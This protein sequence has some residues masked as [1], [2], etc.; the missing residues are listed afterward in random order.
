ML[1][2]IFL[3]LYWTASSWMQNSFPTFTAAQLFDFLDFLLC[4]ANNIVHSSFTTYSTAD[5]FPLHTSTT[6]P[7]LPPLFSKEIERSL[8]GRR[9]LVE[10]CSNKLVAQ[11]WFYLYTVI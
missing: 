7:Q 8:W 2:L 11:L 3:V 6:L 1:L 10:Q 9:M 5:A 4:W